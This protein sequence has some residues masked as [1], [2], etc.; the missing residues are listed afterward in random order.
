MKPGASAGAGTGTGTTLRL[1]RLE[2]A[3]VMETF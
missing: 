1:V 2:D 3:I